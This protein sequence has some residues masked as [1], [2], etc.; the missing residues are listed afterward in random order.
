MCGPNL[1]PQLVMALTL[2]NKLG[3]ER[4]G[5]SFKHYLHKR[6][7]AH[8]TAFVEKVATVCNC[9]D[10]FRTMNCQATLICLALSVGGVG[11]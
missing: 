7:K 9:K 3:A 10:T 8:W 2:T 4:P 11:L 1:T 5:S 6:D